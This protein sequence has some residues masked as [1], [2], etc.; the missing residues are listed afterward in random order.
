ME[1]TQKRYI[2][3]LQLQ[4]LDQCPEYF[5]LAKLFARK[6]FQLVPV[7]MEE[8]SALTQDKNNF[9]L[10]LTLNLTAFRKFNLKRKKFINF[11][12][13]SRKLSLFHLNSFGEIKELNN[14]YTIKG[15]KTLSP[16][17][18]YQKLVDLVEEYYLERVTKEEKWPGGRRARL[19]EM[20][21]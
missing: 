21:G 19:P 13:K 17:V 12:L 20:N 7:D 9:L 4:S 1:T 8:L 3:F 5:V 14:S 10:V 2:F 15:Y 11:A 18:K 16:P 6:G